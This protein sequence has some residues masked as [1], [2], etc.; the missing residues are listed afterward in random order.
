MRVCKAKSNSDPCTTRFSVRKSETPGTDKLWSPD[1]LFDPET[2]VSGSESASARIA[3][4][5]CQCRATHCIF[6][7]GFVVFSTDLCITCL[8]LADLCRRDT[9][10]L[11]RIPIQLA[12]WF[13]DSLEF[14]GHL[15]VA[16]QPDAA[17]GPLFED[18]VE[19]SAHQPRRMA[20]VLGSSKLIYIVR[21]KVLVAIF[22]SLPASNST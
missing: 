15:P 21:E 7:S 6:T 17:P 18:H 9:F 20:A 11:R 22:D 8:R 19:I 1:R 16:G 4:C 13:H 3:F 12:R 2:R 10:H 14:R 5:F